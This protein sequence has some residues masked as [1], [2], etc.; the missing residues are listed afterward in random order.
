MAKHP[1]FEILDADLIA[2]LCN[3]GNPYTKFL[4]NR[5]F[6]LLEEGI[7][8]ETN[9]KIVLGSLISGLGF[10]NCSTTLGHALSYVY[11]KVRVITFGQSP[12]STSVKVMLEL[13]PVEEH[14]PSI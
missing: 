3:S 8:T 9:E 10:G 2:S 14:P 5:A 6:E 11:S 13:R 7:L 1:G 4:C 12:Y